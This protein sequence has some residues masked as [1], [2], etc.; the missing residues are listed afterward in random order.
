MTRPINNTFAFVSSVSDIGMLLEFYFQD[1]CIVFLWVKSF[2]R[3]LTFCGIYKAPHCN[4]LKD[5][6]KLSLFESSAFFLSVLFMLRV[7]MCLWIRAH[8]L[9]DS[10]VEEVSSVDS[11]SNPS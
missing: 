5:T 1:F 9:V 3:P 10:R 11:D 4:P 8:P 2:G 6:L 7:L